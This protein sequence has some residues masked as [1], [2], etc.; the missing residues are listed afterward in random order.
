MT[1]M[2]PPLLRT[3]DAPPVRMAHLGLGAFHRSHQA[4]WTGAVGRADP[5]GIAA[6]TGRSAANAT[7]LRAQDG[8]YTLLVRGPEADAAELVTAIARA[9]DGADTAAFS[10]CLADPAVRLLTLTV[11]EAGYRQTAEGGLDHA[12]PAVAADIAALSPSRAGLPL[13]TAPGRVV[14]GLCARR[15]ADAGAIALVPC[16]NLSGNGEALRQVLMELAAATDPALAAWIAESVSFVSTVVDRITPRATEEDLATVI[17]LTGWAD[18]VPV[19]TEPFSEWVL[20]GDFPGGR[21]PWE[22]A[23]ARFVADVTPYERRKLWLLNGA[24]SILAYAGL[25]RGHRT[26]ADAYADERCRAFVDDW[27][28]EAARHLP[29]SVGSTSGEYQRELAERFANRRIRHL[30]DQVAADG[31][32]KL[33]MRAVPVLRRERADGRRGTAALRMIACWIAYLRGKPPT[34]ADPLAATLLSARRTTDFLAALAPDLTEDAEVVADL[35]DLVA[36]ETEPRNRPRE[37]LWLFVAARAAATVRE[38]FRQLADHAVQV[39]VRVDGD[40]RLVGRERF[41]CG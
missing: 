16:D 31:S 3:G 34:L 10:G 4:W 17:R 20:A 41:E 29:P 6:F 5:W 26:I 8:L 40:T 33:R 13:R 12:D 14:A 22:E 23:G 37:S 19:V 39:A 2:A 35:E 1:A 11:T 9:T 30:L 36:G 32:Q 38:P 28:A 25:L 7:A 24:H 18:R 21:P 15:R 27:W